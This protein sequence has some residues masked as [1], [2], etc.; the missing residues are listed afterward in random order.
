MPKKSVKKI[1]L[2]CAQAALDK[3]AKDVVVLD[4]KGLTDMTDYFVICSGTSDVQIR[5]IAKEIDESLTKK[6]IKI[7]HIEGYKEATW[8]V[9]D[10]FD[11]VVHIFHE[12]TRRFYDLESLWADAKVI[13]V[14]K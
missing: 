3:K 7:H 11:V 4:M 14:G 13:E 8:I 2:Q 9:I 6:K 12:E 5:A 10:L 1:A